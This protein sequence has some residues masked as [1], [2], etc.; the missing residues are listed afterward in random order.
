MHLQRSVRFVIHD[1]GGQ[2]TRSFDDVFAA[3]GAQAI[4][5]PAG[6]PRANA[7]AERW[8]RSVRHELLD[9]PSSGTNAYCGPCSRSASLTTTSIARTD[10]SD[11]EHQRPVTLL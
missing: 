9:A 7:F 1:G 3:V 2:Y 6:A 4:T 5:T 11:N 8:V 10:R